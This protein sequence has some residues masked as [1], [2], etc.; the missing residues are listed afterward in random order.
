MKPR[1]DEAV[2]LTHD[3]ASPSAA[4]TGLVNA[5]VVYEAPVEAEPREE[6]APLTRDSPSPTAPFTH[7]VNATVFAAPL[8]VYEAPVAVGSQD[9]G[10]TEPVRD[11]PSMAAAALHMATNHATALTVFE[12]PAAAVYEVLPAAQPVAPEGDSSSESE[13]SESDDDAIGE[14]RL[15]R[16][17]ASVDMDSLVSP[18]CDRDME[19]TWLFVVGQRVR[20]SSQRAKRDIPS[21]E[22]RFVTDVGRFLTISWGVVV[23]LRNDD[24]VLILPRLR[25]RV[26]CIAAVGNDPPAATAEKHDLTSLMIGDYAVVE[27]RIPTGNDKLGGGATTYHGIVLQVEPEFGT[28]QMRDS[29]GIILTLPQPPS[30]IVCVKRFFVVKGG[31]S[32]GKNK[33][34]KQTFMF[35]QCPTG[36]GRRSPRSQRPPHPGGDQRAGFGH[37]H[38]NN[39]VRNTFYDD[40]SSSQQTFLFVEENEYI[41]KKRF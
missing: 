32:G 24:T 6:A 1:E 35:Q 3:S 8:V 30:V 19:S 11:A 26:A 15:K 16:P 37:S 13:T 31:S 7:S 10:A 21:G 33:K 4:A 14:K 22:T 39:N 9:H 36:G 20:V 40:S 27:T 23:L 38:G 18:Y 12:T 5:L 29:R 2:P 41:Y 28:V 34:K 25:Q 17:F